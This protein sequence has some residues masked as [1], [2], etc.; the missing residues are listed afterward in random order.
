MAN[1]SNFTIFALAYAGKIILPNTKGNITAKRSLTF[2]TR[3]ANKYKS[4]PYKLCG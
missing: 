2:L 4:L 3:V 1:W